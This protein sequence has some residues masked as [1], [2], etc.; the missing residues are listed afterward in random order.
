MVSL[1]SRAAH[2]GPVRAPNLLGAQR[3]RPSLGSERDK[4]PAQ[5]PKPL[6]LDAD[7]HLK[8]V[9]PS[10]RRPVTP[11]ST[12]S[13][14]TPLSSPSGLS[15]SRGTW[16]SSA[17]DA[18]PFA[19]PSAAFSGA[20]RASAGLR[21]PSLTATKPQ[22]PPSRSSMDEYRARSSSSPQT[23]NPSVW[24]AHGDRSGP[25]RASRMP[26]SMAQMTGGL[27]TG[28]TAMRPQ[29]PVRTQG[30]TS[31]NKYFSS[32][33]DMASIA[34]R[35]PQSA[36]LRRSRGA[37]P[38][39][40]TGS[41]PSLASAGQLMASA[42]TSAAAVADSSYTA[43]AH[44]HSAVDEDQDYFL[45]EAIRES[46]QDA[47][48][49]AI[50][51]S[52]AEAE[53]QAI[54]QSL[55][56]AEEKA[57]AESKALEEDAKSLD[58]PQWTPRPPPKEL[59]RT[60]Y[61]HRWLSDAS[62][63]FGYS[64][65]AQGKL[66]SRNVEGSGNPD[67]SRADIGDRLP[68]TILPMDPDIAFWLT[69]RDG[70]KDIKEALD[71]LKLQDRDLILCPINDNKDASLADGGS[72]WSLLVGWRRSQNN[73]LD[74]NPNASSEFDFIHYDSL[75]SWAKSGSL[76]QAKA[77]AMKLAGESARVSAGSCAKQTNC[78]DCGVYVLV[79]SEMIISSYL[80][81]RAHNE[82]RELGA[83]PWRE[84]QLLRVTPEEIQ[85]HREW[86]Y[87]T[88]RC[89]AAVGVPDTASGA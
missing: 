58:I 22:R 20:Q 10:P 25:V 39:T 26:N 46:L 42:T 5:R 28:S 3:R 54:R 47:E 61:P 52:L 35:D 8:R 27:S 44:S 60:F 31:A 48:E 63:A 67:S 86:Y 14:T 73:L 55:Q 78:F 59:A 70:A 29:T 50:R 76:Q 17:S 37:G 45:Q 30:G 49:Q 77:L 18:S 9:S 81:M 89:A 43:V 7:Q 62:I 68:Q 79:F 83:P 65:L 57:A 66:S 13:T 53:E 38:S 87:K 51:Q 24:R 21:S 75:T 36:A 80:R 12:P 4:T 85:S 74:D 1:A 2:T 64:L 6:G 56:E 72:H 84:Q 19:S 71:G 34:S 23:Y 11:L 69:M 32:G 16:L 40:G 82:N 33:A 88:C 41:A 15:D